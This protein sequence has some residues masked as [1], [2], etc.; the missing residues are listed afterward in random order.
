MGSSGAGCLAMDNCLE[1]KVAASQ[2]LLCRAFS[3]RPQVRGTMI[4]LVRIIVRLTKHVARIVKA[5]RLANR[6]KDLTTS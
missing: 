2:S 4:W 5:A 1:S 6:E 3:V